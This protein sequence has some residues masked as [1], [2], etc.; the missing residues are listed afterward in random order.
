MESFT[1]GNAGGYARFNAVDKLNSPSG[2]G[3][4]AGADRL[5]HP[6]SNLLYG[7]G[8]TPVDSKERLMG[9]GRAGG[10]VLGRARAAGDTEMALPGRAAPIAPF[11][12]LIAMT[13]F[14]SGLLAGGPLL[15]CP[16]MWYRLV[17][18]LST[19]HLSSFFTGRVPIEIF[20]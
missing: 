2:W 14:Q 9:S 1:F 18:N 15:L 8:T 3:A 16:H 12:L 6:L 5:M 13:L 20:H 7:V 4:A 17:S 10:S 19:A 11:A